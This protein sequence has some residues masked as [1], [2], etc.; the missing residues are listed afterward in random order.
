MSFREAKFFRLVIFLSFLSI[1]MYK[2][3]SINYVGSMKNYSCHGKVS[4]T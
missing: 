1:V 2:Y 4:C 3:T